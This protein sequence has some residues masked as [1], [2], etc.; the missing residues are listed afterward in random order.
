VKI[1]HFEY[2][3]DLNHILI[4]FSVNVYVMKCEKMVDILYINT[5]TAG[6]LCGCLYL[7]AGGFKGVL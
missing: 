1:H 7:N 5:F 3:L 4:D 6:H 2:L